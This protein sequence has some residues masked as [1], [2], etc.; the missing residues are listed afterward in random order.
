MEH[1]E[2]T[3]QNYFKKVF[4]ALND[5]CSFYFFIQSFLFC[6]KLVL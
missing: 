1:M 5:N 3:F 4:S 2:N 6:I